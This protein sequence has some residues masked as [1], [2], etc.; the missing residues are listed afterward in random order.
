MVSIKWP[1]VD[2]AQVDAP[3]SPQ[4]EL[5]TPLRTLGGIEVAGDVNYAFVFGPHVSQVQKLR[6]R[7]LPI[8]ADHAR[9]W[10][11]QGIATPE[12]AM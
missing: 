1:V 5:G 4:Q 11:R 7:E 8:Q 6:P 12:D 9:N 10:R 2:F 3:A